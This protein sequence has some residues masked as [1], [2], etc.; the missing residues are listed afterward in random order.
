MTRA[1][2]PS[3]ARAL[4]TV[5][6]LS[7]SFS[8]HDGPRRAVD[9]LSFDVAPGETLALVGESGCGK[10]TTALAILRL[11]APG[12]RM[13]GQILFDGVDLARLP[14]PALRQVRGRDIA[15][16]FQEPMTSLNPVLTIGRQIAEAIR[17]HEDID[18]A[19]LRQR[20]LELLARVRIPDPERRIDDYPMQLS[21]GQRQRVMIAMAIACRPR[22]LIADEPTTALDVTIQ[23]QILQLLDEL[24]RDLG[25]SVLLITHDLGVV[26]QWADRVIVMHGGKKLEEAPAARLFSA[27][28]HPYTQGLLGASLH[29][30]DGLHYRQA[31]LPEIVVSPDPALGE[32]RFT[33]RTSNAIAHGRDAR[34]ASDAPLLSVRGLATRY[35]GRRGAAVLAV[36]DV[37]FDIANG[38]T[39]GLVGE[40]G[41]G[42]SSLSRTLLRLTPAHAGQALL[43]GTDL[44][45]L[46]ERALKPWR[47]H[48]QMVFQDPYASLNPRHT[49]DDILSAVLRV[50]GEHDRAA[51]KRR[52]ARMLDNV[53]LPADAGRRYPNEFS[54]GQ[55]QRIGIARALITRPA[56]VVLD[57]PVSALDVSV[58]AQILN[59]LVDLKDELGLSYLFISHD[60]AVVRYLCDRV[61]VMNQGRIVEHGT[62]EALWR[63]PAHPY[64]KTLLAAA[65]GGVGV[66]AEPLARYA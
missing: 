44:L 9:G 57:E 16:I 14:A 64:T 29:A 46:S 55:R 38:E 42:K 62:P 5:R 12:S 6:D 10:S 36:N 17:C 35:E 13:Q 59:L 31:R 25:M 58:Q 37:S 2:Q 56:L 61:M 40:S 54:G 7:V 47:R 28:S 30:R 51:R 63:R 53:G 19:A 1:P 33:L 27:P 49:V 50:H 66:E 24:R 22:L 65:P 43:R 20:T 4:L 11:L 23:A 39:L 45:A 21:G 34:H 41:S 3:D 52:V 26:R 32:P 8:A 18:R 60:L 48:I 15:M